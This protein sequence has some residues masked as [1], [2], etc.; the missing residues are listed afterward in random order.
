M[1]SKDITEENIEKISALF[2]NCITEATDEQGR[3]RK[4]IDFDLLRQELSREIVEG[5]QERYQL[6]WPGKRQALLTANAPIAK[7][8]R[9]CREESVDFD[10]TQNL[11]IE[12]DNLDALKILQETYLGKVK[13]IYIDPPYNTGKD[14]VYAD[15]FY[16][17]VDSYL[18]H[19]GQMD[20]E[21]RKQVTNLESNGR[22]HSVWLS[23]M[24]SRL[25]LARNFLKDDGII[26]ISI[27]NNELNNLQKI[28]SE[29]FGEENF[30]SLLIWRNGGTA[31][32]QFTEEHEYILCFA[33]NKKS[34]GFF[35]Y[36]GSSVIS[37]RSIKK[38]SIKNPVTSIRFPAGIDFE[39]EDKI[40][41]NYFGENEPVKIVS[42]IFES[43]N[44]KLANEV[45]IE[46]AWTM[47]E[48]I[49]KWLNGEEVYDQ[50]GQKLNRFYFK[51]N[52]VLQYEKTKGTTHPKSIIEGFSTKQGSNQLIELFG[53]NYFSFPK[54]VNLISFLI[55]LATSGSD[56]ILDFFAGSSTTAHAVISSNISDNSSRKFI[57]IQLPESCNSNS[58]AYKSGF[59]TIADISKERICQVGKKI[60]AQYANSSN[61][62]KLDLGF[63]VLKVDS[64]NMADVYY[65]TN[66]MNQDLLTQHIDNIKPDRTSEDILFQ[67]LLDWGVDLTLPIAKKIIHDHEVFFIDEGALVACFDNDGKITE[68]FVKELTQYNPLRVIF[69]DAGFASDSVKINVTQI[70]KQLSPHTEVKTI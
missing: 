63:R 58:E 26:F 2:P 4:K 20:V 29:I 38:P 9:P 51:S 35:K 42:G 41:P 44:N 46:A 7:T 33:K 57:M 45:E 15:N 69:R 34:L 27:D 53:E 40:F 48:M 23:M 21:G 13:M 30:V 62:E 1:H 17:S 43:K 55:E 37:D 47:K 11:F 65:T 50:K 31:A 3:L 61:I 14:F 56:I 25:K 68:E 70:F 16:D 39:S 19:S 24:F 5:P 12:G 64:S 59:H 18:I 67:V 54:P 60:K 22:F 28:C 6:N 32:S 8:L 36:S 52:G 10:N 49:L 66:T